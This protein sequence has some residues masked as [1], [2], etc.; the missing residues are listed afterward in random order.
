MWVVNRVGQGNSDAVVDSINKTCE[1]L[2]VYGTILPGHLLPEN[3]RADASEN[4]NLR[5]Q[6]PAK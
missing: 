3:L 1:A 6:R 4:R 2:Q 5:L